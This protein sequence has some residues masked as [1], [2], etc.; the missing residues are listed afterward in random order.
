M[1]GFKSSDVIQEKGPGMERVERYLIL[2]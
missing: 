1:V 2:S